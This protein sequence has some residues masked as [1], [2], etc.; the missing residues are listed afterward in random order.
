MRVGFEFIS[1]I[2]TYKVQF[3][4]RQRTSAHVCWN[5]KYISSYSGTLKLSKRIGPC[6]SNLI[7]H[8]LIPH[9]PSKAS[10]LM[11]LIESEYENALST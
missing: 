5:T 8:I 9:L 11:P 7:T 6:R 10:Y 2:I 1:K 4:C 3:N